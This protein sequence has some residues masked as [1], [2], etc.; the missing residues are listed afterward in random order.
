MMA[1]SPAVPVEQ[2]P[3]QGG[4]FERQPDGTLKPVKQVKDE[5]NA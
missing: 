1:K 2:D 4:S 5:E 3:Q